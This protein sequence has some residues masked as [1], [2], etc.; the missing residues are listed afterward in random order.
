MRKSKHER[1]LIFCT[2]FVLFLILSSHLS[3]MIELEDNEQKKESVNY[4]SGEVENRLTSSDYNEMAEG[5]GID[6][7]SNPYAGFFMPVFF[8]WESESLPY[9]NSKFE[10]EIDSYQMPDNVYV[11]L[12][13]NEIVT[14]LRGTETWDWLEEPIQLYYSGEEN[15]NYIFEGDVIIDLLFPSL[16]ESL[17]EEFMTFDFMVEAFICI[18]SHALQCSGMIKQLFEG[19]INI[20]L[21]MLSNCIFPT[22]WIDEVNV[23]NNWVDID[24]VTFESTKPNSPCSDLTNTLETYTESLESLHIVE[25][26]LYTGEPE[27]TM[28]RSSSTKVE[29][30]LFKD[31]EQ[32][33]PYSDPFVTFLDYGDGSQYVQIYN[34]NGQYEVRVLGLE[35]TEY[36]FGAIETKNGDG[37]VIDSDVDSQ[38]SAGETIVVSKQRITF[39]EDDEDSSLILFLILGLVIVLIATG[40]IFYVKRTNSDTLQQISS[41]APLRGTPATIVGSDGYE[42]YKSES[43]LVYY[44]IAGSQAQWIKL[45]I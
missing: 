37:T 24:K 18:A 6:D 29:L 41:D 27:T 43:G 31:G 45:E 3:P 1:S 33:T 7:S 16:F 14:T 40:V 12:D 2:I 21:E 13:T 36:T 23:D 34:P 26:F 17:Q 22:V 44:R 19:T 32:I 20:I 35:Y 8:N 9:I 4:A 10:I 39:S 15:G 30:Q 28:G 25:Y 11:K 5:M 42:W 38:I